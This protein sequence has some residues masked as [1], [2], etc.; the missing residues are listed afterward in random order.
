MHVKAG[1]RTRDGNSMYVL[2]HVTMMLKDLGTHATTSLS[3]THFFMLAFQ[4]IEV[5]SPVILVMFLRV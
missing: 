1:G 3:F 4:R 2:N 5:S